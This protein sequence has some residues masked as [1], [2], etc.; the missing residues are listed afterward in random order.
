MIKDLHFCSWCNHRFYCY[1]V[2]LE[3][4]I[5]VDFS[6]ILMSSPPDIHTFFIL[7]YLDCHVLFSFSVTEKMEAQATILGDLE[8]FSK[9]NDCQDS[10][11]A[12]VAFF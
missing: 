7:K 2:F 12:F 5:G 3:V 11:P 6:W 10:S 8:K 9:T 1:F 4:P